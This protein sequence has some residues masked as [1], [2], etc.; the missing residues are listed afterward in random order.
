M[1]IEP[2]IGAEAER[3]H[4]H[5]GPVRNNPLFSWPPQPVAVL[6]WYAAYWLAVSTI[7]IT[8]VFS[9]AIYFT[10]L[11]ALETMQSFQAGWMV[12][13]WLA[14]L[15]PQAICA[16]GLHMWLYHWRKQGNQTKYDARDLARD[17]GTYTFG[18]QVWDNMFWTLVS[19]VTLWTVAQWAVFWMMAN[20]YAPAMLFPDNPVWFV[21]MFPFLV[22]WSSFHFYWVHRLLHV[23]AIYKHA[24]ALHHRNVNVGPWSGISMHPLE[25]FLFYT[26]FAIHLIVPSH[27]IHIL[28]HGYV[29]SV[30]PVFSHS[31][32]DQLVVRDEEKAKM[33]DFF[34]QLH[35]R[36]FECNYGTVEMPWDKWFGSFHDGSA[37]ATQR[38]RA[39]KKQMYTK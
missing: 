4:H 30:H 29:Q 1:A 37:D 11:P 31:G 12:R 25:H 23:P 18:N 15:L 17:N 2:E 39:F 3:W 36:Y 28:F 9:V 6:R 13:V 27:P 34:H 21:L 32:F 16:G 20:G 7:T 24:H 33:G 8:A 35:H 26:N 14:N 38:T 19:G 10:L 5:P 22:I